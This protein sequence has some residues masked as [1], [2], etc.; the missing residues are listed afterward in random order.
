MEKLGVAFIGA[1]FANTF[2]AK[3]WIGVRDS[4]I[5]AVC[6]L[7]KE[8][9]EKL[10]SLCRSLGIGEPKVYTDVAE[11]VRDPRVNAVW[12]GVPNFARLEIVKTIVEEVLQ[13][14]TNL[15]GI[16][17]EKP[18][19]RTVKEAK[20]MLKLVEK[21]GLLHGYLENQVFAPAVVRGKEIIWRRGVPIAGRP[22]LARAAE[23]H[24]GPH[25]PW[26]W[27]GEKSG[28]GVLLDMMCHSHEASRFLLIGP[29][30]EKKVLKPR[31]I[32]AEIA[33]LKWTRP[34]YVNKLKDMSKGAVDYSKAPSED[35][36]RSTVVYEHEDGTICV[37][38]VT[39]SWS[40]SGAGLRLT[41]EL[42]GPEYALQIN[43]L[44]PELY[45]FFS[46]AVKGPAG[47][48]LV[49]KQLAEQGL[50]PVLP[51]ESIT[52][53]YQAEDRHMVRSFLQK[54]MPY[55]NW[56]DGLFVVELCMASYMAAEK[57]RKLK[58][59]ID[60]LEEFV[61]KVA[62]GEWNHRSILDV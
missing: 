1:G 24:S 25:E 36:A 59:P 34:N 46:R 31:T 30:E 9:A 48:D 8:R 39:T 53:G 21:A 41:F 14:R 29:E 42:L 3:G 54:K 51:D 23:E 44:Q 12:L 7:H 15:I 40:F 11:T 17:C 33:L 2:H 26:F 52:Y 37:S 22:Y 19:A 45:V 32:N 49:E 47:E 5:V 56:Y 43:T 50:M 6:S 58:F 61:P 10:A 38:E 27:Q 35:F 28:G 18:L 60:G 57:G 16:A 62:K 20:E 4:E 55:E 13:G